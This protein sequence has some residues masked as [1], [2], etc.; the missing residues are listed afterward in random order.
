VPITATGP[1]FEAAGQE[2]HALA[3]LRAQLQEALRSADGAAQR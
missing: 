1:G 2:L 3:M